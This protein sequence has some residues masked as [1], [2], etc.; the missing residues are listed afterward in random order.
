MEEQRPQAVTVE[1]DVALSRPPG[2]HARIWVELSVLPEWGRDLHEAEELA[3][4]VAMT[5][6]GVVMPVG[7]R[8]IDWS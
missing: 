6:E 2:T 5:R 3:C 8:I 4:Q 7:A 1:V